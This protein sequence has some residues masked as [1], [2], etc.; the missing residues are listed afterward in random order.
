M[1][2]PNVPA[3]QDRVAVNATRSLEAR[4]GRLFA[5]QRR[6]RELLETTREELDR[7][8]REVLRTQDEFCTD[9][10]REEEYLC[11]LE[12][13]LGYDPRIDPKELEDALTNGQS[14]EELIAELEAVT[15]PSSSGEAG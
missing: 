13:V 14:L 15:S 4:L 11:V 8:N 5:E 9:P 12:R 1:A 7:V 3:N 10:A 6:L 2:E